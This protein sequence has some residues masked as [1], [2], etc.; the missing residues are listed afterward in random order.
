MKIDKVKSILS[1]Y[2]FNLDVLENKDYKREDILT[3]T[4]LVCNVTDT[5]S[6]RT[7][8]RCGCTTCNINK[9]VTE[10]L[11]KSLSDILRFHNNLRVTKKTNI[12]DPFVI[13]ECIHHGSTSKSLSSWLST[14]CVHCSRERISEANLDEK[15][16]WWI[17]KFKAKFKDRFDYSKFQFSS[18]H[19]GTFICKKHGEFTRDYSSFLERGCTDCNKDNYLV[20]SIVSKEIFVQRVLDKGYTNWID[21]ENCDY[22]SMVKPL[23]LICKYHGPVTKSKAIYFIENGCKQCHIDSLRHN[24]PCSDTTESFIRKMEEAY[25]TQFDYSETLYTRSHEDVTVRC[26]K[27]NYSIT[28]KAYTF[29]QSFPCNK[30]NPKSLQEESIKDYIES[31]IGSEVKSVR[32][33]WLDGKELDIYIPYHKFAIEY[34][35]SAY[36]HSTKGVS[37]FLDSSYKEPRYHFNKWE[38]CRNND[39]IL[40]SIYDFY[41]KDPIK[42]D[43]YKSKIRHYLG[44]DT[45][46]Y[47]RKCSI[48]EITNK[49]AY[50]MYEKN[51]I[52]GKGFPYKDSKSYGLYFN[53]LLVMACTV[54]LLYNQSTK[55]FEY[56]LHR[57]CTLK[58][59]SVIGGVSKLTAFLINT[60]GKFK[61]QI[62]LSSGGSTLKAFDNSEVTLRYFWV[63]LPTL[64]YHHRNYCQ[65]HLLEKHFGFPLLENDTESSY[66][67]RLNY[68][69]VYDNGICTLRIE[70]VNKKIP[71]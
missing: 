59:Y 63:H 41:W 50:Q 36:H 46:V 54:G 6:I 4:C 48:Q 62:T 71:S 61:Y 49:S 60:V 68:V 13:L 45:K 55:S 20:T 16:Q 21:L 18:D 37:T 65:K 30:C 11:E 44:F 12:N 29:L 9:R 33:Y 15:T 42:Q 3:L 53:N 1:P 35:G 28:K 39:V 10:R 52:E 26:K 38:A 27:H 69:K 57:I 43:I 23:T 25:P 17:S 19:L 8:Q 51:H 56:K 66:M 64:K 40:L 58:D 32:P 22:K 24:S 47:A 7:F 67:E 2:S 14:G 31:L 5:K 34:N 70:N